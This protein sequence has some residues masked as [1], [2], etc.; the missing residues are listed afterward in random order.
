[1]VAF[2]PLG[3]PKFRCGPGRQILGE[4]ESSGGV[5]ILLSFSSIPDSLSLSIPFKLLPLERK[6][7]SIIMGP[8]LISSDYGHTWR[9]DFDPVL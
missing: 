7:H 2:L 6:G 9:V 8:T 1:M 4:L 5:G 3:T